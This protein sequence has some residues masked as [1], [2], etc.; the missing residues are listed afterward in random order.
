MGVF[1]NL[2]K[3]GLCDFPEDCNYSS[4]KFS[5][6]GANNNQL[7]PS[8]SLF[9]FDKIYVSFSQIFRCCNSN[10]SLILFIHRTIKMINNSFI[11]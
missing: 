1:Y 2:F 4:A 6:D 5:Q 10:A 3:A 9:T 11:F 8:V 7:H